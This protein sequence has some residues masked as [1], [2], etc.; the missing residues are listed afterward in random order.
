M[1]LLRRNLLGVYGV[2]AVSIVSGLVVT[3]VVIHAIGDTEFGL[4][5][6]IGSL[7][8]YLALLDLGV[9]PSIVRFGAEYRGRRSPEE[10]SALASTGLVIYAVVGVVT[11]PVGFA[12]AYFVPVLIELPEELE[13]PARLATGLLVL[14][15]AARFPLGL[16]TNLLIAQQ[17]W[18][19]TNLGNGL[20]ILLYAVAVV[21]LLPWTGGVVLLAALALGAAL[22]RLCVPLLWVRKELPGLR[23]SRSLVSR[24]RLRGLLVFSWHNFLLHVSSKVVFSADVIVVGVL[25][26]PVAAAFYALPAKLFALAFGLGSAATN[27][28]YPAFAELEGADERDRQ[29]RLLLTGLRAGAGLTLVLALPLLL[30]PDQLLQAWVGP[31]YDDSVPVLALLACVLV[32][33][34]PL[35]FVTQFLVARGRQQR[36]ALVLTGT[37]AVNVVLSVALAELVG[38]WGVALS[39]LVTDVAALAYVLPALVAPAAGVRAR[40]LVLAWARPL[41][42]ALAAAAVVLVG[43]ARLAEP[44]TLLGLAPLGALWALAAG[45]ALWRFGLP[46]EERAAIAGLAGRRGPQVIEVEA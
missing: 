8:I 15:A 28:V 20:S 42:P 10:T 36:L 25:L 3:P 32:V 21:A 19:V 4:W 5:S 22:V 40:E 6:F 26:G 34:Q 18:D 31:G 41:L 27:L 30:I 29:R 7:V 45:L 35:Y 23:F 46:P 39:T 17:R 37:V 33:H 13:W 16:F 12:L 43:A 24:E 9:G 2:Y 44:E 14:A 1:R 11:I 38:I